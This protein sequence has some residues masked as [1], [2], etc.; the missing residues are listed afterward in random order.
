MRC[1]G[2][3]SCC[4]EALSESSGPAVRVHRN[5]YFWQCTVKLVGV[6]ANKY[7]P[8]KGRLE[9]RFLRPNQRDDNSNR[10]L[11]EKAIVKCLGVYP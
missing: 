6:G 4:I 5:I 10:R 11:V 1:I 9:F 3:E 8:V 7:S 2:V